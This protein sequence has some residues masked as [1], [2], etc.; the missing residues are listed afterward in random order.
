M[1]EI[2]S[3]TTIPYYPNYTY[4]KKFIESKLYDCLGT[5]KYYDYILKKEE[6]AEI[7]KAFSQKA[8]SEGN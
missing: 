2:F 3:Y 5:H 8:P 4:L 7:K 6:E 1:V